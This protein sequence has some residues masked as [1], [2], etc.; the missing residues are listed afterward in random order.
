MSA[1]LEIDISLDCRQWADLSPTAEFLV[2]QAITAAWQRC[3]SD[4]E[5]EISVFLTNAARIRTLNRRFRSQDKATNVLSFLAQDSATAGLPRMLGDV[6]LAFETI[7]RE[8][9]EQGKPIADHIRHL[10]VHGVLHLLGYDHQSDAEANVMEL[11]EAEILATLG[12]SDPYAF[13]A[14]ELKSRA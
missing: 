4:E 2:R 14:P 6:V 7:A 9:H 13:E 3:G 8:A 10:C 11:L 5:A 12:V 1:P